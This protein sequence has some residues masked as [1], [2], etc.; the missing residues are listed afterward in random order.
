MNCTCI[1]H[2]MLH[3]RHMKSSRSRRPFSLLAA[4]Y[5]TV[6]S[7]LGI[8]MEVLRGIF[9]L[10]RWLREQRARDAQALP[11]RVQAQALPPTLQAQA[12]PPTQAQ[13]SSPQA[14]PPTRF[15]Y[16]PRSM[17]RH[18]QDSAELRRLGERVAITYVVW[19][20]PG[21]QGF[22][23]LHFGRDA[24]G[25]LEER[26]PG[27]RYSYRSGTRLRLRIAGPDSRRLTWEE[28]IALFFEEAARHYSAV[29]EP[30]P[31]RVEV[32]CWQ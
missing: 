23:G 29:G 28:A 10:F 11:P 15:R 14:S 17:G 19:R 12:S 24:W 4:C 25:G 1:S 31:E 20:I 22:R 13:A 7:C 3:D 21:G 9:R 27:G 16:L 32:F 6:A 5:C 30:A 26:L 18:R 8:T 2:F